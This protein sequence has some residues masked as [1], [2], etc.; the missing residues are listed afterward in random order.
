MDKEEQQYR[1]QRG[2]QERA[3]EQRY[4][5]CSRSEHASEIRAMN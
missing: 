2:A 5:Q 1:Q 4:Q 3:Q